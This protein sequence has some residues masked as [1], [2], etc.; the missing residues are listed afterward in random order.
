MIIFVANFKAL[1]TEKW[2]VAF[3]IQNQF[4]INFSY[5]QIIIT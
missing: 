2:I 5:L 3:S 4:K 1:N